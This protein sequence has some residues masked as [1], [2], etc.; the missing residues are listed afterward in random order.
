VAYN[1]KHNEANGEGG[2]DGSNDNHSWNCGWE[3]ETQ[4]EGIKA[5]R[6]R[7]IKNALAMLM[8]SQGVPMFV[9]GD[10]AGRTQYGNNNAY[11]HDNELAWF[12]WSL[13][14]QNAGLVRFFQHCIAFRHAHPVLRNRWY[15]TN[16]AITWHGVKAWGADYSES[17]R[18]LAFM[19]DGR[20]EY[21]PANALGASAPDE[22]IYVV[23]NMHWEST[24][25][26]LPGLPEGMRWH[27]F[28]NT[29]AWPA[30]EIWQPGQEPPLDYQGGLQ[31][32]DRSVIILVGR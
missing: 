29:G 23:M 11:C 3:G 5:L 12:D 17:S 24:W 22:L 2:R 20:A 27:V 7:Q 8:V 16:S 19:L 6:Q 28:A 1:D 32:G 18:L 14:E 4:D 21:R 15:L 31:V 10:E 13:T 25:V 30:E 9:M 26:E